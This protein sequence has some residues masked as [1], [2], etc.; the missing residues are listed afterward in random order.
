MS[1]T[2]TVWNTGDVITAAKLTNLETQYSSAIADIPFK[3]YPVTVSNAQNTAVETDIWTLTIGANEW[4]DKE[5]IVVRGYVYHKNNKGS[6][7]TLSPNVY[8]GGVSRASS[9]N[10]SFTDSINETPIPCGL[11][12][13]RN[14]TNVA[15]LA[16][17]HSGA[18]VALDAMQAA[19][20]AGQDWALYGSPTPVVEAWTP[21]FSGSIIIK[22]SVTP[23]AASNLFYIKTQS[24][25]A[26]KFGA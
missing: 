12:L 8:V 3:K 16:N 15:L 2:P 7:G 6:A 24:F 4:A 23:S 9:G 5:Y 10:T 22:Q 13:Q 19:E 1:Y 20:I 18:G 21:T 11:V 25:I 26:H 14:G 17:F